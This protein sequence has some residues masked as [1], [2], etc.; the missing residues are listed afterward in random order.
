MKFLFKNYLCILLLFGLPNVT[1]GAAKTK[2]MVPSIIS[3][4]AETGMV[5]YEKNADVCRPP[6][7]MIKIM[8]M[9]LVSEG[10]REGKWTLDQKITASRKAQRMGGTQVYLQAGDVF[11]LDHLMKA[12]SVA[13]ANDA[14][15]AV[16]EGLWGSE[17]TYKEAMNARAQ[18]LGM[19]DS[20]FHSVHGLPPD[21]GNPYDATTARDMA[22]LAQACVKEEQVLKWTNMRELQFRPGEAKKYTTN[23][24]LRRRDDMDGLKTG[25]I[26]KAGFCV[27]STIEKNGVRI[28]AVLMGY[29]DKVKRFNEAERLLDEG[30]AAF[31]RGQLVAKGTEKAPKVSVANCETPTL[32]LEVSNEIKLMV[33]SHKWDN[34]ELVWEHPKSVTAPVKKGDRIGTVSAVLGGEVLAKSELLAS[35]DMA[36]ASLAWK[37]EQSILSFFE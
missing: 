2:P 32:Q 27:T 35:A 12:V 26:S 16:A 28:I 36:E 31:K 4:E 17:D 9:L 19:K 11:T 34:I 6:A 22:L 14:T 10:L 25:F 20:V 13:S 3:I 37:I 5:L 30:V 15:M 21:W 8:Q 29:Q 7:S 1:Y 18:E 33:L 23:K 24:L